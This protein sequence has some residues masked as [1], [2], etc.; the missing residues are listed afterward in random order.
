MEYIIYCDESISNGR[1]FSD[2]YGGALVRSLDYFDITR[3]LNEKK[4][5]LNLKNEIK[6]TKVTENYLEK[7]E[8]MMKLFFDFI[9]KD[10]I[11]IRIMFR[12]N[13]LVPAKLSDDQI[14]KGFQ[15]L[16]YQFIKHAFGLTYTSN[17][18]ET[19][20]RLYFDKLPDTKIKNEQFLN[21]IYA[22]QSLPQFQ[23][24]NIKI[25]REDIT[26]VDSHDH[27]ILQCMDIILGSMA[28]RLNDFHKVKLEG[29]LQR[30]KRTIAKEK[31]YKFIL[32]EIRTI[33]PGF[34]IGITT[35]KSPRE[36]I[37]TL[38]YRHWSFVP[39]EFT[40]DGEKFK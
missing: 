21:Y 31:L 12:Q 7:Y 40:V 11:K 37:W 5:S 24:A 32:N 27:V 35:S 30:G 26:E 4:F 10:K 18:E 38:S 28:F 20:L 1:Y 25:R 2:F 16:Y 23:G 9:R 33:Y 6:W 39:K 22:L 3:R 15:L 19:F 13:A 34:N 36:K 14:D 17:D 29:K 8:K